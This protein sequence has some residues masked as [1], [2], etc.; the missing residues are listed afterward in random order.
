MEGEEA[1]GSPYPYL[2]EEVTRD[3]LGD[4]EGEIEDNNCFVRRA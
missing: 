3:L 2:D 1:A 4:E